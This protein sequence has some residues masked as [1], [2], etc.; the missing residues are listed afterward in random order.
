VPDAAFIPA[1]AT[2]ASVA[3]LVRQRPFRAYLHAS[4]LVRLES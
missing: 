3:N 1:N 2:A 4:L